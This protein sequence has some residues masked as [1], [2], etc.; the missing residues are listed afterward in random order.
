MEIGGWVNRL[1]LHAGKKTDGKCE[2]YNLSISGGDTDTILERFEF[3]AKVRQADVIIFQS[4]GNDAYLKG[5]NGSNQIPLDKFRKN[6]EEII[7]KAENITKKIVFVGFK[8]VDERKTMPVSWEDIY[9]INSE[10]KKYSETMRDVCRENNILYL[11][12]FGLLKNEDLED[13]LH[14]NATGHV[15]IFEKVRSLLE[16]N[17]WI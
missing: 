12:I 15:K 1:W 14:P 17:S 11:D 2:I 13:G 8:N 5:R 7:R 4:G 9:Y 16:E 10:I 6:L 3:E